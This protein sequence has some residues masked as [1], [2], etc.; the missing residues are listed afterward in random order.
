MPIQHR[1]LAVVAHPDDI[2]FLMSGTLMHLRDAGAEIH[3]WNL[4]D[5]SCGTAAFDRDAIAAIRWEESLASAKLLGATAHPPITR[6]LEIFYTPDLLARAAAVVRLIRPTI[7][8]TQSPV[9]YMEDHQNACRLVVTATFTRGMRNFV[10]NPSIPPVFGDS[11]VYHALPHG[12]RDGL[13]QRIRAGQYVD[14]SSKLHDKR[15]ALA[16]HRSQKEW[17]DISQ[18]LDSYLDSMESFAKSIGAHSG[19]FF[20]AEGWRRRNHLGFSSE[21]TDPLSDLLGSS[22]WTDP[23]FEADLKV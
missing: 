17:L 5:G 2:E 8:L 21:E 16:C 10:T 20:A 23:T 12:L 4:A 6:D 13:R 14:I 11:V 7:V 15:R 22:S 18:G 1:V 19:R 3:Y 9:D